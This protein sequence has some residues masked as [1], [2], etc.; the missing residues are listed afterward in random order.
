MTTD[1]E[2]TAGV[3]QDDGGRGLS[4]NSQSKTYL[5]V[6]LSVCLQKLKIKIG[7]GYCIH[8]LYTSYPLLSGAH[9]RRRGSPREFLHRMS[10]LTQTQRICVSSRDHFVELL[11]I[12]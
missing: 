10:F 6:Y 8:I 3:W 12:R 11:V 2:E 5:C 4:G 9:L 7:M 1:Y